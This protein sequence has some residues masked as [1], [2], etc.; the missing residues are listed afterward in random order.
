MGS[1]SITL[2]RLRVGSEQL[3][4]TQIYSP[5]KKSAEECLTKIFQSHFPAPSTETPFKIKFNLGRPELHYQGKVVPLQKSSELKRVARIMRYYQHTG[6]LSKPVMLK[7]EKAQTVEESKKSIQAVHDASIPGTNGQV[8]AGMRIADD[9]LSLTRNILFAI[10]D[11]GQNDPI[12][13]H[14]GYYAGIF[15][16]FFALREL[17][18]G[19]TEYK[20]SKLIGDEEGIRRGQA[21][22][23]SGGIISTAS[24]GYLSGKILDSYVSATAASVVLGAANV[25][26]GVGSMLAMGTSLLGALRCERFNQRL[27][28]YLDNPNLSEKDRLKSALKYLKECISISPEE[29]EILVQQVEKEHPDWTQEAKEKLLN[30]KLA[31]LTEVKVKYM[32]RRTSSRSLQ[33]IL[34]DTDKILALLENPETAVEGITKASVLI[35]TIQKESRLKKTL[36]M[37]GFV[38]ALVSFAAMMILTFMSAGALPFVLYGISGT[39][40]LLITVYTI[41]GMVLKKDPE[42]KEIET[43]PVQEMPRL[44]MG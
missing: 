25:L 11:I 7:G 6:H 22:I 41:A 28:E 24:F 19:V 29:R 43:H 9:T 13:S 27:N 39:I 42:E 1:L 17:D 15:W 3:D 21:R 38:A 37:L 10:P 14:L 4:P 35:N 8:L 31:D 12:V 36:Y 18:D 5:H 2:N 32:K 34:R 33:L 44:R 30:Q 23:L 16:T 20:R 40:Y 26:F